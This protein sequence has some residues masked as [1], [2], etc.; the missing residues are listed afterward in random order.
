MED[1]V[2]SGPLEL[3]SVEAV[4]FIARGKPVIMDDDLAELFGTTTKKLNQQVKRNIERFEERFVFQLTTEEY[5][6]LRSQSVTAKTRHGGR[7]SMPWVFT[8]HGIPMAA[9]VLRNPRA[10]EAM[11]LVVDVF[12]ATRRQALSGASGREMQRAGRQQHEDRRRIREK[13]AKMAEVLL[14]YE[15]NK[16]DQTSVKDEIEK[17]TASVLDNVKAQLAT[18]AIQNEDII[19]DI[20]RKLAEAEKLRA[21]A[22]KTNAE[23]EAIDLKNFRER[24]DILKSI[25]SSLDYGDVTPVLSTMDALAGTA[26]GH[27]KLI[28]VTPKAHDEKVT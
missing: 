26:A 4:I 2:E 22:R 8:E 25:E 5:A 14:D 3:K 15:I 9:S 27:R 11:K 10:V 16:R 12:V 1:Q 20:Q 18:K 6:L 7:R 23:A 21:E 19:A 24:L 28:D 13:V 17:L